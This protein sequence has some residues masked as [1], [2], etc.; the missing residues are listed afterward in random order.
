MQS[1]LQP[2]SQMC[3]QAAQLQ[4]SWSGACSCSGS[5]ARSQGLGSASSALKLTSLEL[6]HSE[7]RAAPPGAALAPSAWGAVGQ[8]SV[9]DWLMRK[10]SSPIQ[11][12]HGQHNKEQ[13]TGHRAASVLDWLLKSQA[14]RIEGMGHS[15]PVS[16]FSEVGGA[17]HATLLVPLQ[18]S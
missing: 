17:R 8:V 6:L 13:G 16:S 1:S 9:M 15:M 2:V 11:S 12:S 4:S 18:R 14:T 3:S 10:A 7:G 5:T